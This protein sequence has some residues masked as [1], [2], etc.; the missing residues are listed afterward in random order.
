MDTEI[1]QKGR[2][3]STQLP[4]TTRIENDLRLA[5]DLELLAEERATLGDAREAAELRLR[6][7]VI[8]HEASKGH[9]AYV[10]SE[11]ERA[12]REPIN[13]SDLLGAAEAFHVDGPRY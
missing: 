13:L 11:L 6:A 3:M 4:H 5:A 7:K 10:A 9:N 2:A 12:Q 1:D 8:R